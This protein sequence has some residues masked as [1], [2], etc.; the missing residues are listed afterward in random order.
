MLSSRGSPAGSFAAGR[1]PRRRRVR[2]RDEGPQSLQIPPIAGIGPGQ[3][4][5]AWQFPETF[6]V[7]EETKRFLSELA[8]PDVRVAVEL[9]S[10]VAHRVVQ[11]ERADPAESDGLVDCPEQRLVAVSRPEVVARG[12]RVACVNADTDAVPICRTRHH[13][14]ELV[15]T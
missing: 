12:E 8:V 9:R 13:L 2:P 11:V 5:A 10:E 15:G 7:H 3:L 4:E 6:L 1:G 14:R